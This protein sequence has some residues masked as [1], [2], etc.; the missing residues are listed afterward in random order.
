MSAPR[1]IPRIVSSLTSSPA[2]RPWYRG[3][4][5]PL[6]IVGLSGRGRGRVAA[7]RLPTAIVVD[8]DVGQQHAVLDDAPQI[9]DPPLGLDSADHDLIKRGRIADL[10]LDRL[11]IAPLDRVEP[12]AA[13]HHEGAGRARADEDEIGVNERAQLVHVL[14][15]QGVAPFALE[16]F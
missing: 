2:R 13:V 16:R 1:M 8:P 6:E 11:D 3:M 4:L 7:D 5:F 14:A 15:A 9:A 12:F 10:D